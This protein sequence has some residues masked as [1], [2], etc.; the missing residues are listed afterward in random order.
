MLYFSIAE[1][2]INGDLKNA[3]NG[4]W[5]PLLAWLI[6]PFMYAG[7]SDLL[8]LSTINLILGILTIF[9]VWRM[10]LMFEVPEG[11]KSVILIALLPITLRI[12]IVEPMDFLLLCILVFY[13]GLILSPDY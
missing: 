9:G 1:K 12:S 11:I 2:Y 10:S 7:V 3:I 8:A 5:G 13:L 4:Y 6:A